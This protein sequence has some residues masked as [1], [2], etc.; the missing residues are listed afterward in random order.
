MFPFLFLSIFSLRNLLSPSLP[1]PA[2]HNLFSF[3]L[4]FPYN[5]RS[6]ASY[7]LLPISPSFYL[8]VSL[9]LSRSFFLSFSFFMSVVV[10]FFFFFKM[11]FFVALVLWTSS[12]LY[13]L[14]RVGTHFVSPFYKVQYSFSVLFLDRTE[15]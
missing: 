13:S 1:S 2:S 4:K 14:L 5:K 10:F 12:V 8:C 15:V 3:D 7:L 11:A 9:S 6:L